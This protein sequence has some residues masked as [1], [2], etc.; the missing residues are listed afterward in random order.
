[1]HQTPHLELPTVILLAL[2][3]SSLW[4]IGFAMW[5]K[6]SEPAEDVDSH[7]NQLGD[8][9]LALLGVSQILYVVDLFAWLFR[10]IRFSPGAP[11][12]SLAINSGLLLSAAAL[13]IAPFAFGAKRWVGIGVGL[14]TAIMWLFAGAMS[15][16]M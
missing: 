3:V 6:S 5:P 8:I 15:V 11:L 16:A 2:S 14:I 9:S 12:P 4:L 10:W 1:M 13:L 7:R